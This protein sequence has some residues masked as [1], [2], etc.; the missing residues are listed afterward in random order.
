MRRSDERLVPLDLEAPE[1]RKRWLRGLLVRLPELLGD[2]AHTTKV[3]VTEQ[4]LGDD[5][6]A[7]VWKAN[8]PPPDQLL[9]FIERNER[10]H[11]V[12]VY[13]DL[14]CQGTDLEPLE[15]EGGGSLYVTCMLTKSGTLDVEEDAPVY[16][17]VRLDVDIYAPRSLGEIRDNTLLAAL[18]GPRL[19]GFLERIE[20]DV[21]AERRAH[22]VVQL[23]EPRPRRGDLHGVVERSGQEELRLHEAHLVA[24]LEPVPRR[25]LAERL[26]A[27]SGD[28]RLGTRR[29][30][31][32]ALPLEDEQEEPVPE[33]R[34][35]E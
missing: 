5:A 3:D 7:S 15:I 25:A 28:D 12:H 34:A 23:V 16:L 4:R 27:L 13:L 26:T 31:G 10:I 9:E 29:V 1:V 8:A 14:T 18:N 30:V 11:Y 17:G 20:R 35:V 24:V 21:P 32:G 6:C 19:A 33:G 2:F 22:A